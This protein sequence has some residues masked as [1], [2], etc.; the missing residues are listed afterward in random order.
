[1]LGYHSYLICTN[2]TTWEQNKR[3][4]ITYIKDYPK[5]IYPFSE[6][7]IKNIKMVFFHENKI[8]FF[9]MNFINMKLLILRTWKPKD[10]ETLNQTER[11]GFNYCDNEFYSCC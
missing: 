2:Q 11:N 10:L 1:L 3:D 6:G 8:R 7:V 9:F 5:N 4:R